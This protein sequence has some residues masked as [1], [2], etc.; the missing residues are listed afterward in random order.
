MINHYEPEVE[1]RS[2]FPQI[3]DFHLMNVG[4]MGELRWRR[5]RLGKIVNK[6]KNK[7][8]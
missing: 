8:K 5:S 6:L 4:T 3:I 7:L 1:V 2:T